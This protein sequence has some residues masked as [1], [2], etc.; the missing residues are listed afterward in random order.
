MIRPPFEERAKAATARSI[1]PVSRMLTGLTS[2][3][4]EGRGLDGGKLAG[5]SPLGGIPKDC[6]SRHARRDLLEQL[7]PFPGDA[8]LEI[9][10]AGDVAAWPRKAIDHEHDWHGAS[11]L[12]QWSH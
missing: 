3:L 11:R 7:H 4:S 5:S 9:H 12:Q 2:I 10:E 1:S 8:V 6:R